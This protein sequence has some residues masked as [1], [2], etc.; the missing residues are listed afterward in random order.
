GAPAHPSEPRALGA[1]GAPGSRRASA[2]ERL[3]GRAAPPPPRR[4]AAAALGARRAAG[5]IRERDGAA[6]AGPEPSLTASRRARG[7]SV[8]AATSP[9]AELRAVLV[10]ERSC[11]TPAD[12]V[13]GSGLLA[14]RPPNPGLPTRPRG[15]GGLRGRRD[16]RPRGEE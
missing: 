8:R 12:H 7:R 3:H 6:H 15:E 11:A 14:E 9:S 4:A 16:L 1:R 10:P 2:L 13:L 5:R